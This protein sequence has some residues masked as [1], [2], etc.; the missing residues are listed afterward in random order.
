M[1][2]HDYVNY[3]TSTYLN[4]MA[5]ISSPHEV[6]KL[7]LLYNTTLPSSVAVEHVIVGETD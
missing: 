4:K 2:N 5:I 1:S 3:R 7:F 6:V